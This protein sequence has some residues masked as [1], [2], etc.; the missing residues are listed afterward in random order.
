MDVLIDGK[1]KKGGKFSGRTRGNKVVN[2]AGPD[3]LIGS[4]VTV[5]ITAAGVNSLSGE[6]C[7]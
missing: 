5:R 1:S 4:L 2:I 3:S 7:E 6:I